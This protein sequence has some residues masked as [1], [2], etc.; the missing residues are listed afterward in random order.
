MATTL[1]MPTFDPPR[2]SSETDQRYLLADSVAPSESASMITDTVD[3]DGD[4]TPRARSPLGH[5]DPTEPVT[6][7]QSIAAPEGAASQ[8]SYRGFK[9][10]QAY[11]D[12]LRAWAEG[13]KYAE[14]TNT[15]L[16]GFYGTTT[17]A[18]YAD[19]PP[20]FQPLGLKRKWKAMKANRQEEKAKRNE[21][22]RATIA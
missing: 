19:R 8:G 9:S 6:R 7:H 4:R 13:R 2:S 15:T 3:G 18:E 11:L 20:A 12:A 1:R 21:E 16:V 17:M 22:R 14:P 10:E 5:C